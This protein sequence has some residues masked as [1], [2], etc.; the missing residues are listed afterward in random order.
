[1]RS[2]QL[3]GAYAPSRP[4]SRRP[5]AGPIGTR[6]TAASSASGEVRLEEGDGAIPRKLGRGFLIARSRVV[7]EAVLGPRIHVHLVADAARLEGGLES[8]PHGIDPLIALRVLDEKWRLD[9][10]HACGLSGGAVEGHASLQ[11]GAEGDGE[12][13]G[14]AAAP[15]EARDAELARGER[16]RL[17]EA[18]AVQHVRAQLALVETGLQ[19]AP[20]V[21]MPG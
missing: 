7:V 20:V 4:A 21:V 2:C 18:G 13:V 14:G 17:Q 10:G 11:V 3:S 5:R 9:V 1:M 16:V 12:E 6:A 19:R 15:A 8:R